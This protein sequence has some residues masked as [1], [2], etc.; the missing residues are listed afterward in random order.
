MT[1]PPTITT[2]AVVGNSPAD[3]CC[4]SFQLLR[5]RESVRRVPVLARTRIACAKRAERIVCDRIFLVSDHLF[6]TAC[7]ASRPCAKGDGNTTPD[8]SDHAMATDMNPLLS[9][10]AR[11]YTDPAI[12]EIESRGL[13]ASSWQF[14][15][16]ASQLQRPGDFFTFEMAGESL[17]CVMDRDGAINAFYNVCQHR[18]HQLVQGSGRANVLTCPYHAW[19]YDLGGQLR[20]GPNIK[21]V[22][23]FRREDI[24]LTKVPI[25]NFCG[26]LFVNL[27]PD[28]R[29]MDEWFPG[30]R[31]ELAA[32]VPQIEQLRPLEWV[33]IPETCNWKVSVENYSEC[34]HCTLNHETFATGIVR[35]ETYDI[36][37][38]G[39]CLRHT[40]EC[41]NLDAMSY[42]IDLSANDY[43]GVYSS[44]FLWPMF[45]FQ[46]YPGNLLNTYHWR[47]VDADHVVVWRGWY[48][49]DGVESETVRQL[50]VQDRE[51][52]VEEDIHLVESVQRGLK[53]RGYRPGPLVMDP[54]C[55]VNSE[56]SIA[57]LQSWMRDAA[58]RMG[59][60]AAG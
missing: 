8:G 49:I 12:F 58:D 57:V 35:P 39:H 43:A 6:R 50:A 25:E 48:S 5:G 22:E 20:A 41:Q 53:S 45:S 52:T 16:H 18:A 40:T 59:T 27:D 54:A 30:V 28:A 21:A 15:G 29:P 14:A 11:Y 17:F 36:Q 55:G 26:F 23:G 51:T 3:I 44:W 32:H 38:Q 47:A 37:P 2:R 4:A 1:P 31:S 60:T 19:S 13:F 24:C 42:P 34:Y 46:V 56:H 33:E 7:A 9:L 10:D